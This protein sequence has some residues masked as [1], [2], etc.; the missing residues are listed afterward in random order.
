MAA[1]LNGF[2]GGMTGLGADA[3]L[4]YLGETGDLVRL[5]ELVDGCKT[6]LDF[7]QVGQKTDSNGDVTKTNS[8]RLSFRGSNIH[9]KEN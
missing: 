3:I 7:R 6:K 8:M 4:S 9:A 5:L 2:R 1:T